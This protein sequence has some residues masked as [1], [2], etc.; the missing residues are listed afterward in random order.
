MVRVPLSALASGPLDLPREAAHY[1]CVVHRLGPGSAFV[2]FEP[3]LGLEANGRI[4]SVERT[5]VACELDTPSAVRRGSSGVTLLQATAKGDRLEQVVRGA[6]ALGVERI[7]L[8]VAER[9]VARP[10]D[11]R[12]ERLRAISVEAARQSGRGDLPPIDG[13]APLAEQLAAL[14]KWEGLKLCL[15][16]QA[17]IP[18][19]E[20]IQ[21]SSPGSPALV[22]VGPEGGLSDSELHAAAQS[23][24]LAA[25][26]GPLILRTELAALAALACFAGRTCATSD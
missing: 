17:T 6:T 20:R 11:V 23:G 8:V 5:R 15:S 24:F 14:A 18:L 13:P 1:L 22:L 7:V 16:P 9:S 19:A 3:E 21:S 2:A 26:L 10:S 12:H 4:V 25:G